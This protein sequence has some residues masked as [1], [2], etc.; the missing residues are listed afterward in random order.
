MLTVIG[1]SVFQVSTLRSR[2][3][4][5]KILVVPGMNNDHDIA[6]EL[7]TDPYFLPRHACS[8]LVW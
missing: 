4:S 1:A 8:A 2:P 6:A 5:V 3:V 7:D